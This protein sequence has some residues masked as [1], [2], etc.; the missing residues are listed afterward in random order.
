M[1]LTGPLDGWQWIFVVEGLVTIA[2]SVLVFIFVPHFPAKDKWLS[3]HDR[4][5]LLARLEVDKGRETVQEGGSSWLKYMVDYKIWLCTLL[6]FCAD[7]YG[8]RSILVLHI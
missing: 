6:F 1:D 8:K 4:S 7:L 2:F 3:E 5:M